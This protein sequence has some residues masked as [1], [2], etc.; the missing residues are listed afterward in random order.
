MRRAR[1]I[2]NEFVQSDEC[3]AEALAYDQIVRKAG[4]TYNGGW[5]HGMN[6]GRDRTW[7]RKDDPEFGQLYACTF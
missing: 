3:E 2:N 5:F 7:D 6:C 4:R 1:A